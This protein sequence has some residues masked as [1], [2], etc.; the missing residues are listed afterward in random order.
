[1][2]AARTVEQ[3]TE[4]ILSEVGRNIFP[5]D[6]RHGEAVDEDDLD[7]RHALHQPERAVH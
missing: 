1:M 5:D 2:G 7:T 4:A 3:Y 6:G